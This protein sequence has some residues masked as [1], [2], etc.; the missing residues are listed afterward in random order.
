MSQLGLCYEAAKHLQTM[1][2]MLI[3]ISNELL[4]N[5]DLNPEQTGKL[6][7][8]RLVFPSPFNNFLLR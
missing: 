6:R 5:D 1:K 2:D 4:D 7:Q 3:S 8:D